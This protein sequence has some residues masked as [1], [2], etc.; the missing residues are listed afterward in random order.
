MKPS[1]HPR[2][3]RGEKKR[4][5]IDTKWMEDYAYRVK[6]CANRDCGHNPKCSC[7]KANVRVVRQ[8][9]PYPTGRANDPPIP[10]LREMMIDWIFRIPCW[11][12]K[13][14]WFE[15]EHPLKKYVGTICM[16]C[17]ELSPVDKPDDRTGTMVTF[18]KLK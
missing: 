16:R 6:K 14:K 9:K 4:V 2:K 17:L 11:F 3:G 1:S 15:Y 12:G 18:N 13:H 8:D 7:L 10:D 5:R